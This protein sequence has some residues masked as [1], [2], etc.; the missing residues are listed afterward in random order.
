MSGGL[1]ER[2]EEETYAKKTKQIIS[3]LDFITND[4]QRNPMMAVG[5]RGE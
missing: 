3:L 2:Q 1:E 4:D 5:C